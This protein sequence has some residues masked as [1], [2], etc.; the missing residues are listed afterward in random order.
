MLP[1]DHASVLLAK[2]KK[3]RLVMHFIQHHCLLD[4]CIDVFV[5]CTTFAFLSTKQ[6]F[7]LAETITSLARRFATEVCP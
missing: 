7:V 5:Y 2:L 3:D 4:F 6:V 1:V